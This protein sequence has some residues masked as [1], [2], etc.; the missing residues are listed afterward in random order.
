LVVSQS[1][2]AGPVL[3]ASRSNATV[4]VS[5]LSQPIGYY[6]LQRTPSLLSPWTMVTNS[7]STNRLVFPIDTASYYYRLADVEAAEPRISRSGLV[8]EYLFNGTAVDTAFYQG[9]Q[10]NGSNSPSG[11]LA[12]SN[13]TMGALR[14]HL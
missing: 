5:W 6:Y 4:V 14:R 2:G 9:L 10:R 7:F 8:A 12:S 11:V 3:S 1:R 13:R